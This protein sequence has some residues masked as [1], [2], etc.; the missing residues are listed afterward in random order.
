MAEPTVTTATPYRGEL[1]TVRVD[2]VSLPDGKEAVR[3]IVSHPSSV[4]IVP[5]DFQGNVLLVRQY[6][7]AV[8]S[9]LLEAPAGKMEADENPDA[10]ALRELQEEVG[11]TASGLQALGS[12]Y[13]APGWCTQMMHAYLATDLVQARLDADDDE[14]IEVVRVPLV[15]IPGKIAGGE[16]RDAKSIA[17][18]L[19]AMR[20]LRDN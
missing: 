19:L 4:C 13:V 15:D 1:I 8:E 11:H 12:F 6:R 5:V 17:S 18:L 14:F 10:T 2:T 3:E 7:K 16:I 20:V 9:F